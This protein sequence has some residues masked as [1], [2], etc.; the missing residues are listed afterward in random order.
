M[1]AVELQQV[2]GGE[3]REGRLPARLVTGIGT[4]SRSF[5]DGD[6]FLALRGERFDGHVYAR[7]VE[8]RACALIGDA[9]GARMWDDLTLPQLIVPDTLHALGDIAHAWRER[10]SETTWVAIS[11]SVGKT[12]LRSMLACLLK[13]LGAR[14]A[15]TRGNLNNL[16]GVPLTMLE[17]P[18]DAEIALIECGISV[19]GEMERLSTIVSPDVAV[20][21]AIAPAHGEGLGDLHGVA[22]EK[23]RLFSGLRN[24]GWIAVGEGV[25]ERLSESLQQPVLA[26]GDA[27]YVHFSLDGRMVTFAL[28]DERMELELALPARH[29]AANMA[30]AMSIVRRWSAERQR[31]MPC[32]RDMVRVLSGWRPSAGRMRIMRHPGGATIVDDAYNANPLSMQCALDTLRA[33]E[34]HRVAILGDMAEL[35][36]QSR[37]W[38]AGL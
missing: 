6:A 31:S 10:L 23:A 28:A 13:E 22:K 12:S 37:A 16:I 34:G 29:W 9:E 38:H 33:C 11:G 18:E 2:T 35:G 7:D 1:S 21:T 14:V 19:P 15:G 36:D 3:W 32:L 4:D 5:R 30:L 24:E 25:C 17:V 8:Q 20:L 26:P 27:D